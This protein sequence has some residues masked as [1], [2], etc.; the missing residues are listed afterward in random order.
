MTN[1]LTTAD[2]EKVAMDR[3]GLVLLRIERG[4]IVMLVAGCYTIDPAEHPNVGLAGVV[5]SGKPTKRQ[6]AFGLDAYDALFRRFVLV[7][8]TVRRRRR[9][10]PPPG[11]PRRALTAPR[12]ASQSSPTELAEKWSHYFVPELASRLRR[13]HTP[14]SAAIE[15][16]RDREMQAQTRADR[17]PSDPTPAK[18]GNDQSAKGGTDKLVRRRPARNRA[19]RV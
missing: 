6:V 4:L 7:S 10:P 17:P 8:A 5:D 9:R 11:A 2:D 1:E 16:L 18:G 15:I 12:A 3:A 14:G 19:R 13:G